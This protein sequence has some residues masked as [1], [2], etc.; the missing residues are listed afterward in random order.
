MTGSWR[1]WPFTRPPSASTPRGRWNISRRCT[2]RRRTCRASSRR[3]RRAERHFFAISTRRRLSTV[4]EIALPPLPDR[5]ALFGTGVLAFQQ[6]L[7]AI[8]PVHGRQ[9]PPRDAVERIL[10]AHRL[11]LAHDL[12]DRGIDER[13]AAF[14]RAGKRPCPLHQLAGR[15]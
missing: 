13:R 5:R 8:E 14:E 6:I 2:R 15:A 9:L 3:A 10:K 11:G 12:L 7:A 4:S 1:R